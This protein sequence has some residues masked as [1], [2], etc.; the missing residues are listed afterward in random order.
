MTPVRI[1]IALLH[2]AD[3]QW[4]SDSLEIDLKAIG[5]VAVVFRSDDWLL[6][7]LRARRAKRKKALTI[8]PEPMTEPVPVQT[9]N[10]PM[11]LLLQ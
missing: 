3:L 5:V 8:Q 10:E 4:L 7:V 11:E 9:N 2:P 1:P 6:R